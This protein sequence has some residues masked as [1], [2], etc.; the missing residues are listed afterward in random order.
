[1]TDRDMI[2]VLARSIAAQAEMIALNPNDWA[3]NLYSRANLIRCELSRL[4]D[5]IREFVP[6]DR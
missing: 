1:M 5:L 4:E 3:S 2:A 6:G